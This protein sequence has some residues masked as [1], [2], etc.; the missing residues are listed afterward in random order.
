MKSTFNKLK[1]HPKYDTILNWSKLVSITGSAQ[2]LVQA[3]S[4]ISGILIIRLLP[5]QE[6]AFYTLANTMLGT[7]TVLAD[8]GIS[9]GVMAEGGKVWQNKQKL[10]S[11]LMT[12]LD[13]RKKFAI[14][15]LLVSLPIL[16]YLL[17]HNGASWIISIMIA[18][19]LIPAFYAALSDSLLEIAPKLHQSILPLQKN[20]LSV[21]IGRLILTAL[22]IFIFPW[23]YLAI[24]ANGLPRIWGNIQL[25]KIG[26]KFIEKNQEPDVIVKKK[27]LTIVK[28][29]MPESIYYCLSGQINIWLISIFGT[30]TA[31]ASLGALGRF[32]MITNL[33]LVI[34]LTLVIPRFARLENNKSEILKKIFSV[35]LVLLFLSFAIILF[36]S[37]FSDQILWILGKDYKGLNNIFI[38][39]IIGG[40]I[41]MF[42]GVFFSIN[43][44]K[45]WIISPLL[46]I[47]ISLITTIIALL[48]VNV[49]TLEGV[50]YFN[51]IIS[52]IQAIVLIG[53][54]FNKILKL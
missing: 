29:Q 15:S 27:I 39:I 6:Y 36:S 53:Y 52:T 19:A 13:L 26:N 10:G 12:G 21:G 18:L 49:S 54:C 14:G 16:L 5:V 51:I 35:T 40:C 42:Q 9:T 32:N 11:V 2:I 23:A 1:Q 24:L 43:S 47:M 31:L 46:Y 25:R 4:F 48:V 20:Q 41:S 34:F 45:G 44:S 17:L 33:F 28:R 30:T 37:L 22:S 3:V 38:L 8:G 7:M 50:I